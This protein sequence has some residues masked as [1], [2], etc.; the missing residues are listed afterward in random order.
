MSG[1]FELFALTVEVIMFKN[2]YPVFK[3]NAYIVA[4]LVCETV[5]ILPSIYINTLC[6]LETNRRFYYAFKVKIGHY[7]PNSQV[8]I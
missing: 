3:I 1:L 7:I 5:K 2:K 6:C 8:Q 4:L